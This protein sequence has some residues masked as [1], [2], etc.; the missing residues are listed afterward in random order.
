MKN[1]WAPWRLEF[2]SSAYEAEGCFLCAAGAT[3]PGEA[4][5]REQL[6]IARGK[7]CFCML[8]KFPYSNGHLLISPYEHVDKLDALDDAAML[9][10]MRMA[11]IARQALEN[12]VNAQGFNIGLNLGRD[13]GAG[14]A[15][16]LHLHVV[17]RWRGDTNFLP[18][19]SETKVIPQSLHDVWKKLRAAWPAGGEVKGGAQAD[20]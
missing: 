11:C 12:S 10:M 18:V 5:D 6:I 2:V 16:H 8:N 19:I 14:V 13:A 17:P 9:E 3:E 20:A 7:H 4:A 15:D 1:L